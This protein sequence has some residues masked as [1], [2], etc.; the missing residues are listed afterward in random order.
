MQ[1]LPLKCEKRLEKRK[2][3]N[4]FRSLPSEIEGVDFFSNDYLGFSSSEVVRNR[5]SEI[6]DV[7]AY[8]NGATGSRLLSGN[9]PLFSKAEKMIADF[10]DAESALIFNSGYDANLGFFFRSTAEG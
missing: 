8:K 7:Q 2:Y 9:H 6:M 4:S 5:T 3:D 1:K 10:H